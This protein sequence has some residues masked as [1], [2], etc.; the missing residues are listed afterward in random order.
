MTKEAFFGVSILADLQSFVNTAYKGNI[1]IGLVIFTETNKIYLRVGD[2]LYRIITY[3]KNMVRF[4]T[5]SLKNRAVRYLGIGSTYFNWNYD[6]TITNTSEVGCIDTYIAPHFG[7]LKF[8]N[9]FIDCENWIFDMFVYHDLDTLN[10]LMH[11]FEVTVDT[12]SGQMCL[13]TLEDNKCYY[14]TGTPLDMR[15]L[16]FAT[17]DNNDAVWYINA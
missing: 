9:L 5:V 12:V 4:N 8:K 17:N 10:N 6:E 11:K 2:W 7:A 15:Y 16:V 14:I 1:T 3:N 13:R